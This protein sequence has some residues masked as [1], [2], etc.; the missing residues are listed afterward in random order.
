MELAE[1]SLFRP[2]QFL[3]D[4]VAS[5]KHLSKITVVVDSDKGVTIEDCTNISRELSK[6]LDEQNIV[7]ERYD[8]VVTSPGLDHPLKLMRQFHKNKGRG[9]KVHT[10]DKRVLL[11]TLASASDLGIVLTQE[12]KVG[13]VVTAQEVTIP[14]EEIEKAFVMISFK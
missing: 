3:V 11:G 10:R 12:S 1:A 8:L 5:S 14:F 6:R 9:L 7:N 2:D 13:K 4:V